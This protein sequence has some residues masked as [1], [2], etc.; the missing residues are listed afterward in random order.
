MMV[1]KHLNDQS[2]LANVKADHEKLREDYDKL[3]AECEKL[4]K[5]LKNA[6]T[7]SEKSTDMLSED[8]NT[9]LP[10]TIVSVSSFFSDSKI[11]IVNNT[12]SYKA[13]CDM[14]TFC[15]L[16]PN[17]DNAHYWYKFASEHKSS[18]LLSILGK[19]HVGD[20]EIILFS[21]PVDQNF[22]D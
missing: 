21:Q 16:L 10:R 18:H 1:I 7:E 19:A 6:I 5:Q 22:E 17:N 4:K 14:S 3:S 15:H 12:N 2:E 9:D 8:L 11:C 20:D 13:N